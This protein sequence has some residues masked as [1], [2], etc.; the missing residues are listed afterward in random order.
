MVLGP[1]VCLLS[2][3]SLSP[4]TLLLVG[5]LSSHIAC[6]G[7]F[8]VPLPQFDS[9]FSHFGSESYIVI[10]RVIIISSFVYSSGLWGSFG[11]FLFQLSMSVP[12]GLIGINLGYR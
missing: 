12:P 8:G 1:G 11:L 6:I 2:R 7:F 10:A 5:L 9:S 4:D 3:H